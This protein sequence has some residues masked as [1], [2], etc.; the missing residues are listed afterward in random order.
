MVIMCTLDMITSIMRQITTTMIITTIM[1][2]TSTRMTTKAG[3]CLILFSG[4][5]R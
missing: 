5:T 3:T 1:V 4:I 2:T